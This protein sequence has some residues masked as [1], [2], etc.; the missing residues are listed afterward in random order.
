MAIALF[1]IASLSASLAI[2]DTEKKELYPCHEVAVWAEKAMNDEPIRT[3]HLMMTP[4]MWNHESV[5]CAE[6]QLV[7]AKE[8]EA[9]RQRIR[10]LIERC[11]E[12]TKANR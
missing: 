9:E 11:K 2:A 4:C 3:V 8:L 7:R 1:I 6:E 10:G 12:L 5:A